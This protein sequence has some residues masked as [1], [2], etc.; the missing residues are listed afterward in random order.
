MNL[1]TIFFC[2]SCLILQSCEKLLDVKSDKSLSTINSLS[3]LEE[4]LD[5]Y[6]L[7]YSRAPSGTEVFSDN[8][9]ITSTD[10]ATLSSDYRSYYLWETPNN[11]TL[12]EWALSYANIYKCNLV[13]EEINAKSWEGEE[14]KAEIIKGR[15]FFL[16]AYYFYGLAQLFA[17]AYNTTTSDNDLG[18]VLKL[19]TDLQ[20]V[21]KRSTVEQTYQQIINDFKHAA[22]LLPERE[23]IKTRA[24]RSA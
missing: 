10:W 22:V 11:S 13:L 9:Y 15:A 24:T 1:K 20:E 5:T 4:L 3:D 16:R 23:S 7:G 18:I 6:I 19:S 8:Y 12:G 21:L 17:K 14:T 2:I